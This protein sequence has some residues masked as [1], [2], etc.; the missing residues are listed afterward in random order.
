LTIKI[1]PIAGELAFEALKGKGT[2]LTVSDDE[3]K[4]YAVLASPY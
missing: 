1:V 2:G 3:V 4:T